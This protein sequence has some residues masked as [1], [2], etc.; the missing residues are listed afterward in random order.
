MAD[1]LAVRKKELETITAEAK[2]LQD[3]YDQTDENGKPRRWDPEDRKTFERLCAEGEALQN[4]IEAEVK[5]QQFE[6]QG[7]RLREVSNPDLPNGRNHAEGKAAD[8]REIAGYISVG[9]A[10]L[11]SD[12]FKEFARNDYPRGHVAVVQLNAAMNGKNVTTGP[13][14]EPLVPLTREGRKMFESFVRSKE[15]K[16]VPTLG[17]GVLEPDRV[18]R[19]PQTVTDERLSIRDVISTG[20]TNATAVEYVRDVSG[21]PPLLEPTGHGLQKPELGA[22]WELA[23][24]PVR[25]IAGWMP[26]QNQQL[27]DW[28]QLRSLIDGRLRYAVR[29][30]EE[31][32]IM[33]GS[34]TG[35]NIEGLLTVN[36]TTDIAANG[37]YNGA[38]HTLIDVVRMGITDV[39]VAGY[40]ANAVVMH[41]YDWEEILLEKGTDERY[42][43]AV[44]T[45]ANGSRIW[46]LRV[47]ESIGAQSKLAAG[48]GSG[49][50]NIVVGDFQMGAQLLDR[51]QMTVQVGLVDKQ[52]IENMRTVLAEERIAFPI[53]A[54]A[55][56]AIFQ[57]QAGAA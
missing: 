7:R 28:A 39:L 4:D 30:S 54:P 33:Y 26:V 37:R 51:M 14:G 24:A 53:Y 13:R 12:A 5:F 35:I 20:Q 57:T 36:G 56:F 22:E 45:D 41:P 42:V 25:T 44:V 9:D 32:Q 11:A 17:T 40:Q 43:W 2:K 34:G 31:H 29:R 46:G 47:V 27:E 38:N 48:T 10:V 23:T 21:A 16:A 55:A 1:T 49:E 8:D 6:A 15:M 3:R 19:I 52:F 50:R 18:A